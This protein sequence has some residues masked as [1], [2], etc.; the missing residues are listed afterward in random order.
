MPAM[1][2]SVVVFLSAVVVVVVVSAAGKMLRPHYDLSVINCT[3]DIPFS[4]AKQDFL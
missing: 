4:I 3:T 1:D 2:S